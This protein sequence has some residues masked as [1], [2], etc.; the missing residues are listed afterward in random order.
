[1]IDSENYFLHIVNRLTID[2]ISVL[3]VL[4]DNKATAPF[5][6]MKKKELSEVADIS[7]ANLRKTIYRLDVANFVETVTGIREHKLYVTDLGVLAIEK[8]L[9]GEME[10]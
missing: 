10:E 5:K 3:G 8:S 9:E 1:M 4:I 2:D 6:A 7:E